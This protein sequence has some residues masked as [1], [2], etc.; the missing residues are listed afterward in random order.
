MADLSTSDFIILTILTLL[1]VG[2]LTVLEWVLINVDW[3]NRDG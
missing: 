3:E 1:F 2:A